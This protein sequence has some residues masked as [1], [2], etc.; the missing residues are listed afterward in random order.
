MSTSPP[1][2]ACCHA[3]DVPL[4]PFSPASLF[5]PFQRVAPPGVR[6]ESKRRSSPGARLKRVL[7]MKSYVLSPK[8][9]QRCPPGLFPRQVKPKAVSVFVW[10]WDVTFPGLYQALL[11]LSV[12][13]LRG[14]SRMRLSYRTR[15]PSTP[16]PEPSVISIALPEAILKRA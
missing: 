11:W 14:G 9:S 4:S 16:P 10:A 13:Y 6:T 1:P 7:P 8:P 15:L 3:S 2:P 5:Q 12:C